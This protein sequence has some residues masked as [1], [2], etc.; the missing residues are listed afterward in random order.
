MGMIRG[1]KVLKSVLV[2]MGGGVKT[3]GNMGG[4]G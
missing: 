2:V 1:K 4:S 3:L